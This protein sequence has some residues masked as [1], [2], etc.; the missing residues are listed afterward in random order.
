MTANLDS[1][2]ETLSKMTV[3]E[4]NDLRKKLEETWDVKA[5]APMMAMAMPSGPG[6]AGADAAAGP[7]K[8]HFDVMITNL[9]ESKKID[10]IK[11]VREVATALSTMEVNN[12]LNT[13]P[14]KVLEG[15][16]KAK[17]EEMKAKLSALGVTIELK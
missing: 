8:D 11:A 4:L 3:L 15:A 6:A 5:A 10:V 9:G 2:V 17:A 12:L 13:L 7:Q 16:D 1:I 14:A